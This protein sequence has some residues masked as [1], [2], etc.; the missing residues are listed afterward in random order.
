[1]DEGVLVETTRHRGLGVL[2]GFFVIAGFV[3]GGGGVRGAK[4]SW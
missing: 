2:V 1:M 3:V 4:T